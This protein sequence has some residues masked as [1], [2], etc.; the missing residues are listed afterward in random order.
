M[1]LEIVKFGVPSLVERSA[2]VESFHDDLKRLANDM[3]ETMYAAE[4]VGLAAP[5]VGN[6]IR[7]LV[8]DITSGRREGQQLVLV[9]PEIV[10]HDGSQIGEEGCLSIPGFTAMVE[11]P[12]TIEFKA[13]DLDGKPFEASAEEFLARVLFHEIDHLDGVLYLDRISTLKRELI[14][15]KIGKLTK[16]GEW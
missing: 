1:L 11:R 6:N 4:G 9:N 3:F 15:R 13:R 8:A 16:A 12:F 7:L 5:Q 2:P 14:K 10:N